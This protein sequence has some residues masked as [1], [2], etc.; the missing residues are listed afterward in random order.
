[1]RIWLVP[2]QPTRNLLYLAVPDRNQL[3]LANLITK[4][5]LPATIST[6][7]KYFKTQRSYGTCRDGQRGVSEELR[8]L[9]HEVKFASCRSCSHLKLSTGQHPLLARY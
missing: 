8:V 4:V 3:D 9:N 7:H 2:S 1:M 6:F 5:S